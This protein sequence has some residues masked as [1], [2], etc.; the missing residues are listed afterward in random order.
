MSGCCDCIHE[1][2]CGMAD[3]VKEEH[4]SCPDMKPF[5]RA[6]LFLVQ[7]ECIISC[8][9]IMHHAG[10]CHYGRARYGV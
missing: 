2:V 7:G 5:C 8:K 10:F 4:V 9:P 1:K 6:C 3:V